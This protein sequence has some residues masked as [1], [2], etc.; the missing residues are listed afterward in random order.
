MCGLMLGSGL[1]ITG[2]LLGDEILKTLRGGG[3][4]VVG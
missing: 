2:V 4:L 1:M 3:V